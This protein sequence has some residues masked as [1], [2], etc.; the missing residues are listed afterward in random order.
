MKG[1]QRILQSLQL[2][3]KSKTIPKLKVFSKKEKQSKDVPGYL[4]MWLDK[5]NQIQVREK[6]ADL[7][8]I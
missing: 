7:E 4:T 8:L 5:D 3:Y 2:F 1:I 6:R